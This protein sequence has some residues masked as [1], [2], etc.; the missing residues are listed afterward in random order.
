MCTFRPD[1]ANLRGGVKP[2]NISY[3]GDTVHLECDSEVWSLLCRDCLD[4]AVC[5]WEQTP[6]GPQAYWDTTT[7]QRDVCHGTSTSHIYLQRWECS[8]RS[9]LHCVFALSVILLGAFL[10]SSHFSV[11]SSI[12]NQFHSTVCGK[13]SFKCEIVR[14]T[15]L[16]QF[17]KCNTTVNTTPA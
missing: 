14:T 10:T 3:P 7:I 17:W 16:I 9:C 4:T 5:V 15:L 6:H 1:A 2:Y 8:S 11:Y 12:A 13:I